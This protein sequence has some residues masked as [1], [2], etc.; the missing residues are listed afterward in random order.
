[1]D[2][3]LFFTYLAACGAAAA[4]GAMIQPGEWY[5]ALSKPRWT[6]PDWVFPVAWTLLYLCMSFAAMRIAMR[7]DGPEAVPGTGQALAFW[8]VQIALNVLW[9]PVFFGLKRMGA[10]LVI[11]ALLWL[12]VA[13]TMVSFWMIDPVAGALFAPYLLWVT[14]AS[15]LNASVWRRNPSPVA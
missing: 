6:P 7:A 14:I 12:A 9:T 15:A 2:L 4:T 13:A 8:S 10:G 5:K 11:I 1:M 3:A